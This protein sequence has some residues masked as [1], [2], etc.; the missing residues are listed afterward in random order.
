MVEKSGFTY[1]VTFLDE[2]GIFM[3]SDNHDVVV[4]ATEHPE[5]DQ[6]EAGMLVNDWAEANLSAY[7]AGD[8]ETSLVDAY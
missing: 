1:K 2:D 3:D 5:A 8:Y 7:G 4:D 6:D